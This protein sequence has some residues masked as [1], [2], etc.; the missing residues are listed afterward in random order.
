MIRKVVP[1]VLGAVVVVAV[2]EGLR[3]RV[4][5]LL[6]GAEEEFDYTPTTSGSPPPAHAD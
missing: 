6:F 2:N 1:L 3:N 4:L 5:D